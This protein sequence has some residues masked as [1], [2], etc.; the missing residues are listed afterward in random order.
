[1]AKTTDAIPV[2]TQTTYI[3]KQLNDGRV[4]DGR[5][6]PYL[7]PIG[8]PVIS[9]RGSTV[10]GD[11]RTSGGSGG[12]G[13]DTVTVVA[14]GSIPQGSLVYFTHGY[15][16]HS[17]PVGGG[18]QIFL[19]KTRTM[20]GIP[21][22]TVIQAAKVTNGIFVCLDRPFMCA[23]SEV[24]EVEATGLAAGAIIYYDFI[25]YNLLQGENVEP[26]M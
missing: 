25:G 24:L 7:S 1:M 23:D 21:M 22:E 9:I 20:F 12:A 11:P 17:D 15:F 26:A 3:Q 18:L 14:A 4:G 13:V 10:Y 19:K 2:T 6:V 16:W 8:I 5:G